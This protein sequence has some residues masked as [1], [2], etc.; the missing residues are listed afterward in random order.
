MATELTVFKVEEGFIQKEVPGIQGEKPKYYLRIKFSNESFTKQL[1][2]D[3][4]IEG[5]YKIEQIGDIS[6]Q[7]KY[8]PVKVQLQ[9]LLIDDDNSQVKVKLLFTKEK[10]IS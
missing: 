9:P 3:I 2:E 4:V 7:L 8:N 10:K 6:N 1:I 5:R